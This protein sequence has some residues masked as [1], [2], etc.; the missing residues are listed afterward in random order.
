MKKNH[1]KMHKKIF[2]QNSVPSLSSSS[3]SVGRREKSFLCIH[4]VIFF[5]FLNS[6]QWLSCIISSKNLSRRCQ[7]GGNLGKAVLMSPPDVSLSRLERRCVCLCRFYYDDVP[8]HQILEAS[9]R[10]VFGKDTTGL[11]SSSLR[12][13][14]RERKEGRR[15]STPMMF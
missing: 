8:G 3:H 10:E 13:E 11:C 6:R 4:H 1:M 7:T 14:R 2:S 15:P 9:L 12:R 5:H